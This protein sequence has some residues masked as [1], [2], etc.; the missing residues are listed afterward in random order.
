M[1]RASRT[2]IVK[3]P[4]LRLLAAGL[5][6]ALAAAGCSDRPHPSRDWPAGTLVVART[7]ALGRL[8]ARLQRL[9]GTR[10]AHRA[11]ALAKTLPDCEW[12]EG[13]EEHG[14]AADVWSRLACRPAEGGLA[15][16]DRERGDRDI[17]FALP[18]NGGARSVGTLAIA[19]NGD[20]DAELLLPRSAFASARA[21]MLPGAEPPGPAL[22]SH[23]DELVH[24]RLRPEGGL[25]IAALVPASGQA[26]RMF[27]LKSELFA[28]A[29]LDGT[30]EVAVYLPEPGHPMP[31]SA[32]A[33]GFALKGPAV[34]AIERFAS[35]LQA[36]WPVRRSD[37]AVAA[38]KGACLL[39]LNILPDLAPCY[40]A[41]EKA[42]VIGW[43]PSSLRK[44]LAADENRAPGAGERHPNGGISV[45]LGLFPEADARF[46]Q[47][48]LPDA[49]PP[50][51]GGYPW[52]SLTADGVREGDAVRVRV[53]LEGGAGA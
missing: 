13:R 11:A 47:L 26:D 53:Q 48:V 1:T 21:L 6:L 50:P 45:D 7:E 2:P 44:A 36:V 37:F 31:R 15:G 25:D 19:E 43:N 3:R 34:A 30:W 8:L 24:A 29:V 18:A 49:S 42:L 32:L 40:V 9:E 12:V 28:G 52:R 39:D 41:T 17:A 22:L 23:A 20:V 4:H 14:P 35:D 46:A 5:S 10:I 38:A 33:V 51:A 27:R 16:L